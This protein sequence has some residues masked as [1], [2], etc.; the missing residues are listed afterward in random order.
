[1]VTQY[2]GQFPSSN[3]IVVPV[4]ASYLMD[5]SSPNNASNRFVSNYTHN[6]TPLIHDGAA[7]DVVIICRQAIIKG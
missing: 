5:E 3:N 7:S 4:K 6:R 1:M 2:I